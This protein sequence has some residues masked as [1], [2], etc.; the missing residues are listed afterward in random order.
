MLRK[1]GRGGIKLSSHS[2]LVHHETLRRLR[3]GAF[4]LCHTNG[5]KQAE[6]QGR[7]Q[8]SDRIL[9]AQTQQ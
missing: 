3:G 4:A 1:V 8:S 9:K 6:P 2:V 5:I 7:S